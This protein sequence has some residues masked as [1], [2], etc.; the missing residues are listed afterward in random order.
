M[1]LNLDVELWFCNPDNKNFCYLNLESLVSRLLIGEIYV[2]YLVL[3]ENY[4][5]QNSSI[6]ENNILKG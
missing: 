4:F 2:L 6:V 1:L 5:L 3:F